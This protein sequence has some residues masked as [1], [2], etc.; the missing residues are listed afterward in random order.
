[1]GLSQRGVALSSDWLIWINYYNCFT[2]F[3][4]CF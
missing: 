3:N 2:V 1:L 4:Y